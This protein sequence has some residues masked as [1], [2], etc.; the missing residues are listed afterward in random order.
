MAGVKISVKALII[1]NSHVLCIKQ[2]CNNTIIYSLPG[3]KQKSSETLTESLSRECYEEI[4]T[5]ICIHDIYQVNDFFKE[6]R[7][8]VVQYK[9]V[10]EVVFSCSIPEEYEVKNGFLPDKDQFGVEWVSVDELANKAFRPE[11]HKHMI[12]HGKTH[13]QI[14]ICLSATPKYS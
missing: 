5:P 14:Y 4:G 9:H 3:G 1:K 2:R 12:L 7:D 10:L 8:S 11:R 6:K 13:H